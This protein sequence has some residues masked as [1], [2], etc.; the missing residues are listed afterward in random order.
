MDISYRHKKN[1]VDIVRAFLAQH[2]HADGGCIRTDQG[3]KLARSPTFRD[4]LLRKF[5]YT[6]EPT[7]A[8]SPSQNGSA[9]IYNDKFAIC[10]R[11][12]LYGLGLPVTFWLAALLHLV[13]LHNCL[14]HKDTKKTSFEGYYGCKPDL[15]LLK[16]FGA[17]VCMK[18]TGN[19]RGKLDRHEFTGIFLGYAAMD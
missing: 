2:G 8:D 19:H 12:L 4:L 16:L 1:P 18:C 3:G 17:C 14:V 10:S 7:S 5:N 13:Y 9:E 6:I 11:T 15:S